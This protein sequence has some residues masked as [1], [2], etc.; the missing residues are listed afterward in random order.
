MPTAKDEVRRLLDELP[1]TASLEDV[2]YSLY[3]RERIA[4]AREEAKVGDVLDQDEVERR[5]SQWLTE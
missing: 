2:Q 1:D 4:R 3:V 5:M